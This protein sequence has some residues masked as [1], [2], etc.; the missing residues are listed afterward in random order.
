MH[1]LAITQPYYLIISWQLF[2]KVIRLYVLFILVTK[3][4]RFI[5]D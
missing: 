5:L 1:Y 3:V 4:I 2:H